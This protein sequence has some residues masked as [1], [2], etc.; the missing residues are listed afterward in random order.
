M[1]SEEA[2]AVFQEYLDQFSERLRGGKCERWKLMDENFRFVLNG[3]PP[4]KIV[5]EGAETVRQLEEGDIF[6]PMEVG[7]PDFGYYVDEYIGEGDRM[8]AVVRGR[9][10][11]N[12]GMAYS[13]TY[14]FVFEVRNGKLTEVI[15]DGDT[16]LGAQHIFDLEMVTS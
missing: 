1:M 14:L 3:Q 15:E 10:E 6:T 16:S 7:D 11:S 12:R 9:G 13:N 5:V 8:A 2:R 4:S